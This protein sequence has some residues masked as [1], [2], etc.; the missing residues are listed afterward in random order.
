[1]Q[2]EIFR[3]PLNITTGLAGR[4]KPTCE[5][6]WCRNMLFSHESA[7]REL[8][9][10][11]DNGGAG[12][13]SV[14]KRWYGWVIVEN[15]YGNFDANMPIDTRLTP[16]AALQK[17]YNDMHEH[18]DITIAANQIYKLIKALES[19]QDANSKH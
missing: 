17:I 10:L 12:L 16:Q 4:N 3:A 15:Y 7:M 18:K 8:K 11:T 9:R 19:P 6:D 2:V 13:Y 5:A 14:Q 1:M